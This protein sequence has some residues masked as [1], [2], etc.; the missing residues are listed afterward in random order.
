MSAGRP[1]VTVAVRS[2]EL[3][4]AQGL[5]VRT[6]VVSGSVTEA[7]QAAKVTERTVRRWLHTAAFTMSYRAAARQASSEATSALLAAQ[8]EAVRTLVA[9]L[10]D[11][12]PAVRVRA[13]RALLE[14]G[15]HAADDDM[16]E[17]LTELEREVTT[18][19]DQTPTLSVVDA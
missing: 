1:D 17:R 2:G 7:A 12:T 5:A 13:A 10:R 16:D 14:V 19:R 18:W 11:A 8:H 3:S 4:P 15:R 6:L 9:A